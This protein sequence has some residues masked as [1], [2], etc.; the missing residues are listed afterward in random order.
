M[1][2]IQEM[3]A[4]EDLGWDLEKAELIFGWADYN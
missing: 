2:K 4:T 3:V 1:N